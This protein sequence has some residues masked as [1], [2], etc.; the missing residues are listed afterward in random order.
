MPFGLLASQNAM[1]AHHVLGAG[2]EADA[3]DQH[4]LVAGM[5]PAVAQT[6]TDDKIEQ[7]A[8]VGGR[9]A[10]QRN[11]P[12]QQPRKGRRGDAEPNRFG[13]RGLLRRPAETTHLR[14]KTKN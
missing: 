11:D 6:P 8:A 5:K 7:V 3:G 1:H 4:D 13:A 12:P 2:A 10:H 14:Q 9:R